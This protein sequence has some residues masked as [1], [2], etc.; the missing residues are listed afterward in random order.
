ML[1]TND[2]KVIITIYI[3]TCSPSYTTKSTHYPYFRL[4]DSSILPITAQPRRARRIQ[5]HAVIT[6]Q[7]NIMSPK[8]TSYPYRTLTTSK[9]HNKIPPSIQATDTPICLFP[10]S[11]AR[12]A[13]QRKGDWGTFGKAGAAPRPKVRECLNRIHLWMVIELHYEKI[14]SVPIE[15]RWGV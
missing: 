11:T 14:Q 9:V 8:L 13:P 10:P 1:R 5:P 6:P 4:I 12:M 3:Y 15:S 2:T 7:T